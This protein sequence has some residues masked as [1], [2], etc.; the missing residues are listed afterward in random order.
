KSWK[1]TYTDI[2]QDDELINCLNEIINYTLPLFAENI[3]EGKTIYDLVEEHLKISAIGI[4]PLKTDEGYLFLHCE[5]EKD[6]HV[7][8]Y[9]VSIYQSNEERYRSIST[10]YVSDYSYSISS[11]YEKMK[12]DLIEKNKELPNPAVYALNCSLSVPLQE[13]FLPIAKRYFVSK[14]GF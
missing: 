9:A 13:T 1:L 12:R 5:K 4:S 8:Q 7:Y 2:A 11:T 14:M 6:V 3:Q 10:N